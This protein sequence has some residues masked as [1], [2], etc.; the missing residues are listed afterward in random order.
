KPEV[1]GVKLVHHESSKGRAEAANSGARAA[2]SAYIVFLDDDDLDY[3]EHLAVLANAARTTSKT[4]Y[5]DAVSA[6]VSGGET[7]SRMRLFASDFDR[8]L[9]LVD[10]YV[11]LP[12][13]LLSRDVFLD[14]GGF[15]AAF[16]LFEDWEFLIRLA[17]RGDFLHVP[18]ITCEIR[19]IEG[20]GS[21]TLESPEGTPRFR[22]AK[23]QVWNKHRALLTDEVFANV[24]ERQK[25]RL[26]ALAGE[27]VE[28]RG[29]RGA[30]EQLIA[31]GER[32]KAQLIAEL[33]SQSERLNAAMMRIATLEGADDELRSALEA[34]EKERNGLLVRVG[35]LGDA[36]A[37]F[38]ESQRT[39][40]A[41]WSET[42]RLQ[43]LLDTIYRSRTWKLHEI[44]ERMKGRG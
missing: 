15:D 4:P 38:E 27:V 31:R 35:Q 24:F 26:N 23:M 14:L 25:R 29:A 7:R 39:I 3:P 9:L 44:V 8:E 17:Q 36:R 18:R 37:G 43:T 41:L 42:T 28:A 33:Q 32:E 10:N 40:T 30:A 2:A 6:F 34:A 21:I 19:H 20:A 22:A 1:D 5:T 12:T 13:L 16:D 11:P